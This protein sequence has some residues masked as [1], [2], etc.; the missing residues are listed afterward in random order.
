MAKRFWCGCWNADLLERSRPLR[1]DTP[2][3]SSGNNDDGLRH[4]NTDC[5]W[6]QQ[7]WRFSIYFMVLLLCVSD[8]VSINYTP[9]VGRSA[10][11]VCCCCHFRECKLVDIR[12]VR[13]K[14]FK[15][16]SAVNR[17]CFRIVTSSCDTSF[18]NCDNI[19][20]TT[21]VLDEIWFLQCC[22]LSNWKGNS[23]SSSSLSIK[24]VI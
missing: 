11:D 12:S 16:Q 9:R 3:T 2:R 23:S 1:Y 15:I 22:D 4:V 6:Y 14:V 18:S 13:M 21:S 19:W 20:S 5:I 8:T 24:R 10:S 17:R 7:L